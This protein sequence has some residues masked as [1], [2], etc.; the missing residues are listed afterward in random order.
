MT[1]ALPSL[2]INRS[3][4]K[5][6]IVDLPS[7]PL[8]LHRTY[9]V[10]ALLRTYWL[11]LSNISLRWE[12]SPPL[13]LHFYWF[14]KHG[15]MLG[16]ACRASFCSAWQVGPSPDAFC[17][18]HFQ[19]VKYLPLRTGLLRHKVTHILCDQISWRNR[20]RLRAGSFAS[21][22]SLGTS[23]SVKLFL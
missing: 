19:W 11:W 8:S 13:C 17:L 9:S 20:Q 5:K 10:R 15:G 22:A 16:K 18:W 14:L 23:F 3:Q 6:E 1:A 7:M 2:K 21:A 12:I 4:R